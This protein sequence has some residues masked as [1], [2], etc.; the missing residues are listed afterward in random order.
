MKTCSKCK[1]TLALGEFYKR[2]R[3]PDGHQAYCKE[4]E[5]SHKAAY[6]PAYHKT[7]KGRQIKT[8]YQRRRRQTAKG[9]EEAH[10]AKA[11]Y[12]AKNPEKIRAKTAIAHEVRAGRLPQV[13]TQACATCGDPAQEYHHENYERPLAVIPLCRLCHKAV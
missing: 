9:R 2:K 1:R 13:G 3:S 4:C 5:R 10:R 6:S 11:R 8:R 7:P 12:N